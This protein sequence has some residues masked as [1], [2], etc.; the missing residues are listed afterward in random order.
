LASDRIATPYS[1]VEYIA[2]PSTCAASSVPTIHP[3]HLDGVATIGAPGSYF[4]L[5]GTDFAPNTRVRISVQGRAAGA[6]ESDGD[7]AVAAVIYF[8]P[9]AEPGEYVIDTDTDAAGLAAAAIGTQAVL[10]VDST[11]RRID[12]AGG[13]P[14]LNGRPTVYL[15]LAVR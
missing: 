5:N 9:S 3:A 2:W 6:I 7:G 13:A 14:V 12:Y 1:D 10:T 11:A 8:D 15:P 4:P